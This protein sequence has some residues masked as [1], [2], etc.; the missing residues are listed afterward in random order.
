MY[1]TIFIKQNTFENVFVKIGTIL[2][3]SQYVMETL[4][5][6]DERVGEYLVKSVDIHHKVIHK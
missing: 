5:P 4:H 6:C 2:F 1:N 3:R